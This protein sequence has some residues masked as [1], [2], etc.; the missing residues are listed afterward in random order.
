MMM[1]E[2]HS[3]CL[4]KWVWRSYPAFHAGTILILLTCASYGLCCLHHFLPDLLAAFNAS[5]FAFSHCCALLAATPD[6]DCPS[7]ITLAWLMY[8]LDS[9]PGLVDYLLWIWPL[10]W[11]W[12]HFLFAFFFLVVRLFYIFM[13]CL[14]FTCIFCVCLVSWFTDN[15]K[16]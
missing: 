8:H 4:I 12:Q 9:D 3:M 13:N 6:Y 14:S 15:E 10:V 11:A 2:P 1:N 16:W 7:C 5:A